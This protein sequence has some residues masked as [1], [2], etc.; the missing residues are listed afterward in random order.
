[1]RVIQCDCSSASQHHLTMALLP[2]TPTLRRFSRCVL[3]LSSWLGVLTLRRSHKC[4][5]QCDACASN[6][7]VISESRGHHASRAVSQWHSTGLAE[8]RALT[9][10]S[11]KETLGGS[12]L[13]S[14]AAGSPARQY[15]F[16]PP[17]SCI[18]QGVHAWLARF[19]NALASSAAWPR[20][21]GHW[22][23]EEM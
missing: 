5:L 16:F 3:L 6:V 21:K 13:G 4:V 14:P 22:L 12:H 17:K 8:V 7:V 1:M 18:G 9:A 11:S 15:A 10:P 19:R 23:L 2:S 20:C